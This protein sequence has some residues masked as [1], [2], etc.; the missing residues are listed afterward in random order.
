LK[1][2]G[3]PVQAVFDIDL[4]KGFLMEKIDPNSPDFEG[5]LFEIA[6]FL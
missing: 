1:K 6:R 5:F 4:Y 3:E 2:S